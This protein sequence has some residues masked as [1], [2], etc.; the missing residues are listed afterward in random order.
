MA[1][2]NKVATMAL[3]HSIARSTCRAGDVVVVVSAKNAKRSDGI[4][5]KE[6]LVLAV[7]LVSQTFAPFVYHS[8]ACP[9]WNRSPGVPPWTRAMRPDRVYRATLLNRS[10]WELRH[11][12]KTLRRVDNGK[13]R[14]LTDVEQEE[15]DAWRVSYR[16]DEDDPI[17]VQ[18]VIRSRQ[19]Y[20]A[21]GAIPEG[22]RKRDFRGRVLAG[23]T[24]ASFPG[25]GNAAGA[26]RSLHDC[27]SRKGMRRCIKRGSGGCH[28]WMPFLGTLFARKCFIHARHPWTSSFF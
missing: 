18:Y 4:S 16:T 21:A 5:S 26:V 8:I 11:S 23:R 27:T 24:Y 28:S 3:C 13:N 17:V 7:L 22:V 12:K 10:A 19:R 15:E 1:I 6:R 2:A 9:I 20:H 14:T 25:D